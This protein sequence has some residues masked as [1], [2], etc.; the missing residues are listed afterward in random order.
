[1]A[2]GTD[3]AARSTI[4]ELAISSVVSVAKLAAV[5]LVG[6]AAAIFPRGQP[7]LHKVLLGDLSRLLV[8]VVWPAWAFH[9]VA[10]G[11]RREQVLPT[12]PL[13]PWCAFSLAVSLLLGVLTSRVCRVDDELRPAYIVACGFC[14]SVA[15]PMMLLGT[16]CEQPALSGIEKCDTSVYGMIMLYNV[17]WNLC[18]FAIAVPMLE[19]TPAQESAMAQHSSNEEVADPEQ[20]KVTPSEAKVSCCRRLLHSAWRTLTMPAMLATLLGVITIFIPLLQDALFEP[21]GPLR[22]VGSALETVAAP[23]VAC[24]TFVMAASLVPSQKLRQKFTMTS[25]PMSPRAV[26]ALCATR[27]LVVPAIVFSAWYAVEHYL[28]RKSL[29]RA[30]TPPL[31]ALVSLIESSGPAANMPVVF[32][33]KFNKHDIATRLAFSYIFIYA[34]A[35]FTLAGSTTLALDFATG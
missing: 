20:V 24:F 22:F 29:G 14:N 18:F 16:L 13:L 25:W 12:L 6:I 26:F 15:V 11:I 17:V 8:N 30:S 32:L 4:E 27:L 19:G 9:T 33:A 23:G 21:R 31:V 3:Q 7:I 28:I 2:L 10:A 1:M 34:L 35:I 5:S